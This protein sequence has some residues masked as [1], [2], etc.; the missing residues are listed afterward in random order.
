MAQTWSITFTEGTSLRGL[1]Q[2]DLIKTAAQVYKASS[3]TELRESTGQIVRL[4][5]GAE[6]QVIEDSNGY[7]AESYGEVFLRNSYQ[8]MH[9]KYRTSCYTCGK[10]G[11][12]VVDLFM[13]NITPTRDEFMLIGGCLSIYEYD[14]SNRPFV[15]CSLAQGEKATMNFNPSAPTMRERYSATITNISNEEYDY[16]VANY[17]DPRKWQ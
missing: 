16:I 1:G 10:I 5:K 17:L 12:T 15:I 2:S 8:L 9:H 6:F 7:T 11:N 3:R 4:G 13:R 14:E